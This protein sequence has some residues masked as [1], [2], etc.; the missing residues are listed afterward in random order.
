M[1]L[2]KKSKSKQTKRSVFSD[3]ESLS[4]KCLMQKFYSKVFR[5]LPSSMANFDLF[6]AR[7]Q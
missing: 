2:K 4:E 7:N 5:P 3:A 1:A 6:S